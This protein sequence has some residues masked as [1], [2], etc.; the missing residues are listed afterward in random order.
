MYILKYGGGTLHKL[1]H[2]VCFMSYY[3]IFLINLT[4]P[5]RYEGPHFLQ[6]IGN[7]GQDICKIPDSSL[8]PCTMIWLN[9]IFL[10]GLRNN[11][12][13]DF[14][15]LSDRVIIEQQNH[16][17]AAVNVQIRIN[18]QVIVNRFTNHES[19]LTDSQLF[20]VNS[21]WTNLSWQ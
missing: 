7:T 1:S 13:G 20:V 14:V 3:N 2:L 17:H 6:I 16:L 19:F 11:P 4:N 5:A 21:S 8:M 9:P 15:K 18:M 12:I 10:V